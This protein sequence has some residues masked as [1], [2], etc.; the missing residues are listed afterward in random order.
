MSKPQMGKV[1]FLDDSWT[2]Q[3]VEICLGTSDS[4]S[5]LCEV[6]QTALSNLSS[7]GP[8]S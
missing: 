8:H 1:V 5:G 4:A 3:Y 7:P 2:Q 6:R